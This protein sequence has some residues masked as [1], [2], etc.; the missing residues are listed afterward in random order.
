M[1]KLVK[2]GF[3]EKTIIPIISN[4]PDALQTRAG[5]TDP[6]QTHRVNENIIL[7]MLSSQDATFALGEDEW[8]SDEAF[9]NKGATR[10]RRT[11]ATYK[12]CGTRYIRLAVAVR[13]R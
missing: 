9:F 13:I 10:S 2:A 3:K 8:I 7:A 11:V 12:I 6:T 5:T 4:R 1:V